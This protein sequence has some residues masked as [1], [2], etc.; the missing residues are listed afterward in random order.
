MLVLAESLSNL[1]S[2]VVDLNAGDSTTNP[3]AT[4][5]AYGIYDGPTHYRSKL[6]L[7]N[8]NYPKNASVTPDVTAQTFVLPPSLA[9]KVAI[10]YLQ[11]PNV[12]EE[13]NISWAGQI[14]HKNGELRPSGGQVTQEMSCHGGCEIDVPGPGLALVWL[15][16]DIQVGQ[17]YVGDSTVAPI[18][19]STNGSTTTNSTASSLAS[20]MRADSSSSFLFPL[21]LALLLSFVMCQCSFL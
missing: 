17:I 5:A 19:A 3:R 16:P 20:H 18:K 11:A 7:L 13:T 12:T 14:V 4:V 15:D 21:C 6:V 8:F 1:S 2:V 10:R 9:D